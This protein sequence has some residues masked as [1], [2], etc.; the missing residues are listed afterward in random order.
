[1]AVDVVILAAGQGK[2]MKS[3]LPKVLHPLAGKPLVAHVVDAARTLDDSRITL[4]VGH[5]A[6][7]VREALPDSELQWV[8]QTEQLGTGHAV[9][10]A[11]PLLR[12]D[13]RVLVL[14]GDVPLI[15]PATLE[16]LLETVTDQSLGLL[17]VTLEDPAGYGRILRDA[18]GRISAIVEEK[19]ADPEEL[20]ITEINTGVM[21]LSATRLRDWLPRVGNDNAQGEYYLTD[22]IAMAR[23]AGVAVHGSQPRDA[24]ETRGV[25]S[26]EQL[27]DL[28]RA[29]Q[30][31]FARRLLAAGVSLADVERFDC[32]GELEAGEDSFIDIDC[33]FEGRVTLGRGVNVGPHC[34]IRDADIAD[35]V[36]VKSHTCIEGPARLGEGVEVGPYARIRPG[37]ELASGARI[38]NF[39]ETKKSRIGPGSKVNHLSYIGDTEI[40]AGVNIGAGTITCN[41]DGVN[42]FRTLIEDGA[43]VGSNT[44]LVAPVRLGR[45][46]TVG[47]GSTITSDVGEGN[48][49]V[50]RGRQRNIEN[51]Q[52]PS[53]EDKD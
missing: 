7:A 46:S 8:E 18:D 48:L 16:N 33:V 3:A 2:R 44:S 37:T 13:A 39:V 25:N 14:Y 23:E 19:D 10:Q 24:L 45:G 17:T 1:M 12:T 35:G 52:R 11:L 5:G 22:L 4:V 51:W 38:G 26:R 21:A 49:A 20:A 42:K 47:A 15:A 34:V 30:R 53:R 41:Y 28:E 50:G 32:R 31:R 9:M 6:E 29:C 40:G 36:T 27:Q 43:F